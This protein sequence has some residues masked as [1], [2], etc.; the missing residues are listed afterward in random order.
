[1]SGVYGS[2]WAEAQGE[3]SRLSL[4]MKHELERAAGR[5][6]PPDTVEAEVYPVSFRASVLIEAAFGCFRSPP[7]GARFQILRHEV[8]PGRWRVAVR[9]VYGII[10]LDRSKAEVLA[11]LGP[12][13]KCGGRD[14]WVGHDGSVFNGP[15]HLPPGRL[16]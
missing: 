5:D 8:R 12:C 13:T 6:V 4:L 7:S 14:H 3:F 16:P 9:V 15:C 2:V 11:R 1:M 10:N